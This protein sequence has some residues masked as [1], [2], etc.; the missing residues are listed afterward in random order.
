MLSIPQ[1]VRP[2]RRLG[3]HGVVRRLPGGD[4]FYVADDETVVAGMDGAPRLDHD[5]LRVSPN[6]LP[7]FHIIFIAL[8]SVLA[9]FI[10]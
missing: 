3:L 9:T 5:T 8:T 1:R 10:D 2:E 6:V 4:V 7:R